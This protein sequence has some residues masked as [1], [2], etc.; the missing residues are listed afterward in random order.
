M[1]GQLEAL[2]AA[3]PGAAF[4]AHAS[5]RWRTANRKGDRGEA[6]RLWRRGMPVLGRQAVDAVLQGTWGL[7]RLGAGAPQLRGRPGRGPRRQPA[8]LV[9]CGQ[10]RAAC[11]QVRVSTLVPRRAPRCC[12]AE[13]RLLQGSCRA[14]HLRSAG[15]CQSQ[16]QAAVRLAGANAEFWGP[17]CPAMQAGSAAGCMQRL[18][19]LWGV[20]LT[21]QA[22]PAVRSVLQGG[23]CQLLQGVQPQQHGRQLAAVRQQ[24]RRG[25]G[26]LQRVLLAQICDH[27]PACAAQTG[28]ACLLGQGWRALHT[29]GT[30]NRRS[31]LEQITGSARQIGRLA[32]M[33]PA[34]HAADAAGARVHGRA[35]PG[36]GRPPAR[37]ARPGQGAPGRQVCSAPAP[38]C[39]A[40]PHPRAEQVQQQLLRSHLVIA[41][42]PQTLSY[43][44]TCHDIA[45]RA[46]LGWG[47]A[48]P[49]HVRLCGHAQHKLPG[50]ARCCSAGPLG[51]GS[52]RAGCA[53]V[54]P[55][56]PCSTGSMLPCCA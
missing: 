29:G 25:Y 35:H 30:H 50:Q 44:Q 21:M 40:C 24:V 39:P 45:V 46:T 38:A 20:S 47:C 17:A 48:D 53:K 2:L 5:L 22:G 31:A 51:L 12:R 1:L 28:G 54:Q 8:Q 16:V 7:Q 19:P 14:K 4:S 43:S 26:G 13:R 15:A 34:T 36:A 11:S 33:Q 27:C 18:L 41:P 32:S 56:P 42:A 23:P 55:P 3:A 52:P 9:H 10:R 37:G 49:E 6:A